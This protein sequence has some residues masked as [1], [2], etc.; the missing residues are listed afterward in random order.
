MPHRRIIVDGYSLMHRIPDLADRAD[1]NLAAARQHVIR[2][3]ER[4]APSM[5]DSATIVFDGRGEG[6]RSPLETST[7]EVLF[8]PP[9]QTADTVIERI[10]HEDPRP[11]ELLVVASDR[12]ELDTVSAAGADAMSC[13]QF[14]D[15]CRIH[16]QDLVREAK[17]YKPSR[18]GT[19][20]GDFFP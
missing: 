5:C 12:S 7:V 10:V 17:K 1:T 13:D 3:I 16:E 19:S 18:R 4:I 2:F 20:L 8:S 11:T 6:G 14:L 15:V 9:D